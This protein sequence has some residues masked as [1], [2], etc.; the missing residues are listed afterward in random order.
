M[1]AVRWVTEASFGERV[2]VREGGE[3]RDAGRDAKNEYYTRMTNVV[4]W[5]EKFKENTYMI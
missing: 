5:K 1:V 4:N 3:E 2:E